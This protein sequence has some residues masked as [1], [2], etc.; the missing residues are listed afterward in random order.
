MWYLWRQILKFKKRSRVLDPDEIFLDSRNLPSFNTQQFEGMIER[1]ISKQSLMFA[2]V[3]FLIVGLIFAGR[4]GFLQVIQ[5]G[6][7]ALRSNQN[8][9]HHTLVFADRG[10]IYDRNGIQLA[11]NDPDRKYIKSEGFS[12]I[13]G[14]IGFPTEIEL[15]EKDFDPKEYMGK[16]GVENTFN[17]V[18]MGEKGVKIEEVDARGKIESDH[19]LKVAKPGDSVTISIDSRVQAE[20]YRIIKEIAFDHGFTGAAAVVMDIKTGELIALASYPEF[21]SNIMATGKDRA[22]INKFLNDSGN[23]FLNRPVSGL[24]TPGS[25]IKP[26]IGL[27]ALAENIIS[28]SKT[29]FSSGRLVVPNP[30]FPDKPSIFPDNKAHGAVDMRRALAVSSNVYFYT[31][32]GGF[33]SQTGLGI[34]KIDQYSQ[35]FGFGE[36]TGIELNAEAAGVVPSPAWKEKVFPGEPWRLGN[37]YHTS[38]GQYGYLVT[39]LQVARAAAM[40][41]SGGKV[42]KPTLIARPKTNTIE[43]TLKIDQADFQVIQEGMRQTVTNGTGIVLNTPNVKV[44]AKS[45]TAQVASETR[46][47]AWI[48]GYF[49][50]DNPRYSF[51]VVMESGPLTTNAGGGM[52]MRRLLDWMAIYTPE[53]LR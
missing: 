6:S 41:A 15:K 50:Y 42:L 12:H 39:P 29:I 1:P 17:D 53:Y 11:W 18:L 47:N 30:Y 46:I 8:R 24:Y 52:V 9:L 20:L 16:S 37:T 19:V 2:S 25:T 26:Y 7:F 45:G 51:T 22:T 38:I 36:V 33:G 23:L 43:R 3:V 48:S 44:A 28:P 40:I 31:I 13:L 49:P 21:D 35:L 27:A 34:K 10:I 14:Y 5:G 4:I 32:G